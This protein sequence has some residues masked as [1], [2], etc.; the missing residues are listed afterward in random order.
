MPVRPRFVGRQRGVERVEEP[1]GA[2]GSRGAARESV[3]G[4]A[5]T[6]AAMR[7]ERVGARVEPLPQLG[8]D[9]ARA[10]PASD[11]PKRARSSA[12][13]ASADEQRSGDAERRRATM[14]ARCRRIT[15][16]ISDQVQAYTSAI[17]KST[18]T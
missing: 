17:V 16:T 12:Q 18:W 4:S 6:R 3:S 5:A 14:R 9:A 11:A 8:L 10:P 2:A 7:A 1:L 15:V 13:P